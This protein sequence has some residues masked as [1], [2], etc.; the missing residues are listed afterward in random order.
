MYLCNAFEENAEVAQ[1]VE[2]NLAKVRVAGPSPV[3]RS[4]NEAGS[5]AILARPLRNYRPIVAKATYTPAAN[6]ISLLRR[7]A[8]A[9]LKRAAAIEY[10]M[11]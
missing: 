1:L 4:K 8:K 9:L 7:A 3:F 2:H 6:H 10:L 11:P 5:K